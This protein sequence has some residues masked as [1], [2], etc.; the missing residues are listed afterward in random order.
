MYVRTI[1]I[2]FKDNMSKN[3]FVNYTITKAHL[4]GFKK[5]YINETNF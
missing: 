4:E 3:M 5:W 1:K 2:I